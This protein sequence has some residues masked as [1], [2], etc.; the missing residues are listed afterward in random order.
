MLGIIE[1]IVGKVYET[2]DYSI[3]T[4]LEGNRK[5]TEKRADKI[6]VNILEN[7]YILNPIVVNE[8]LEVIDGQGRLE[9]LKALGLPVHY[10]IAQGAG[11]KECAVLN[12]ANTP[13]KIDDYI[14]SYAELGNENYKRLQKLIADY[15]QFT[16][17]TICSLATGLKGNKAKGRIREGKIEYTA[18]IDVVT[19]NRLEYLADF[20]PDLERVKGTYFHY[21]F[22]ILFA[23]EAGASKKRIATCVTHNTLPP[24]PNL[25]TAL[26]NLTEA[27]N[28]G[29][30]VSNRLYLYPL[31]EESLIEKYGWYG[32]RLAGAGWGQR[33]GKEQ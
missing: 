16:P 5:V 22:A 10:V 30:S 25:R 19:R 9:A 11:V 23:I 14:A 33:P 13:W 31:Y 24:A 32:S 17:S 15:D 27:Y 3:F 28:K 4:R 1:K 12:A 29:I 6:K 2:T 20:I 21:L 8:K 18:D 26:D 7:G